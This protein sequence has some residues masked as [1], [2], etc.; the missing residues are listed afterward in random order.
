MIGK[1][2]QPGKIKLFFF[3]L[4]WNWKNRKWADCRAK[5]KA[6]RRDYNEFIGK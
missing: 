4:K 2:E 1:H 3:R 6:Y 5:R